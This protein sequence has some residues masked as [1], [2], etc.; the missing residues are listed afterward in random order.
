MA[1]IVCKE[2][3]KKIS[4]TAERCIHCGA[5]I[6]EQ[7]SS[8]ET[9]VEKTDAKEPQKSE[10]KYTD[11]HKMADNSKIQLEIEFLEQDSWAKKF[12]HKGLELKALRGLFM[13][14]PFFLMF[15][16]MI[17][18]LVLQFQSNNHIA[19]P[20]AH[21]I[22]IGGGVAF[23]IICWILSKI[24]STRLKRHNASHD[25]LIYEKK[26]QRWLRET[27]KIVYHPILWDEATMD[28][29]DAINLNELDY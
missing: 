27:K 28:R 18:M 25:V 13:P 16:D 14:A 10:Q 15:I 21:W 1:L 20:T 24:Y 3:G 9:N 29:F 8:L 12:R 23:A 26:F 6:S 11:Y 22:A 17:I 7:D 4:D 5:F 19:N 2:C